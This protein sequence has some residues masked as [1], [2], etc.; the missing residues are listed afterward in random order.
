MKRI[1]Y[2]VPDNSPLP[3]QAAALALSRQE[4]YR[5]FLAQ[6]RKK[7]KYWHINNAPNPHSRDLTR[8]NNGY[9]RSPQKAS[10]RQLIRGKETFQR[11]FL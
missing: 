4:A 9:L 3:I 5:F 7:Q 1:N 8:S 11:P 10:R 2:S 6:C